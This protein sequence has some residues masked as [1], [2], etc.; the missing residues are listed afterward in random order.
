MADESHP[1]DTRALHRAY[2]ARTVAELREC[3][4]QWAIDYETHMSNVGYAHPAMVAAML[5]R[6]HPPGDQPILD[7]GAGTGIMAELLTALG[8]TRLVGVDASARMLEVAAAR[9]RYRELHQG[10]L[11]EALDF[12]DDQFAAVIAT[13]VFTQGHAPLDAFD[14]LIRVTRSGGLLV[15]SVA[16]AYLEGGFEDKRATLEAAGKWRLV[17]TTG[18]YNSTPLGDEIPARVYVFAAI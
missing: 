10:V 4:D 1:E 6:H 7:A 12:E 8:H 2:T 18:R 15:F 11:G 9:G 3:Y 16:R 14:E 5:A 13:G 17:D